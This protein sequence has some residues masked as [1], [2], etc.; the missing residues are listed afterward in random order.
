MR[1]ATLAVLGVSLAGVACE[2]GLPAG[3]EPHR[4]LNFLDM[5]DQPK[6]KP[7]RGDIFGSRPTGM[8]AASRGALAV[9]E[10]PYGFTAAQADLAGANV[11]NPLEPTPE[12]VAK[13]KFIYDNVCVACHGPEGAGDGKVTRFFPRPPS[14]MTQVVRDYSDG[15]IFHV[16]MRGQASM[17]SHAKQVDQDDLWAV[18][19][20]IR[21]LQ[22]KLPVAPPPPAAGTVGGNTP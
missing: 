22:S 21:A 10:H 18:V 2:V 20:Y 5:G 12:R 19:L 3:A 17:P 8:R 15:R 13:G 9:D 1:S 14:L 11:R 4:D 7:Q 6:L 16:P